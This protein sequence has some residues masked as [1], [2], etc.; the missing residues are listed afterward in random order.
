[1]NGGRATLVAVGV[2]A[3][4]LPGVDILH[5]A[6]I[7][8]APGEL[9]SI[10]GPNG[11]GKSTFLKAVFGLIPIRAGRVEVD[12]VNVTNTPAHRMVAQ[13]VGFVPQTDNVFP[14]LTVEENLR[15]GLFLRPGDWDERWQAAIELFP[16][17]AQR[18]T[19]RA[20]NLSGGERKMVAMSRAMMMSPRLLLL[21][22]PSAAL[23]PANQG[24]VF[25]TIRAIADSGVTVLMVEQNARRAL[26]ISD[27]GYVF[28]QGVDAY[29]GAGRDLLHDDKVID[30]YLGRL[31][32]RRTS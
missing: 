29:T 21:D 28:D 14:S 18:R 8:V 32:Q 22:E 4:Y 25:E 23:S 24:Q 20:G 13:G 15:M 17:L 30:L 16:R 5:G 1:M 31:G 10:I 9:V 12:G 3:G 27:R 26:S 19:Q 7:S 11:A 2:V 6:S